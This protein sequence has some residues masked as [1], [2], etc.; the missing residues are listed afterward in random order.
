MKNYK[1]TILVISFLFLGFTQIN[2]QVKGDWLR[3]PTQL[4]G[5]E[6]VVEPVV[7]LAW[8]TPG[9]PTW[10]FYGN[11]SASTFLTFNIG[12]YELATKYESNDLF[13]YHGMSIKKFDFY[14]SVDAHPY[15]FKIWSGDDGDK[16]EYEQLLDTVNT[17]AWTTVNLTTPFVIDS[18]KTY[19]VG[20]SFDIASDGSYGVVLDNGPAVVSGKGNMIRNSEGFFV[21]LTDYGVNRNLSFFTYLELDESVKKQNIITLNQETKECNIGE[22]SLKELS[23]KIKFET[24]IS[25]AKSPSSFNIYRNNVVVGTSIESS[26]VDELPDGGEYVYEISAV[27]PEGES[28][29]SESLDVVYD[30]KRIPYNTVITETFINVGEANG[31]L[32]SGSS[33]GAFMGIKELEFEVDNI[34]PIVYHSGTAILGPDPFS[35]IDG[36]ERF[37]YYMAAT[38][39]FPMTLFNARLFQGG[40]S[41]ETMYEV[42]KD[43]YESALDLVTPIAFESSLEKI[44]S[45]KYRLNATA[46]IVGVYNDPNTVLHVVLTQETIEHSWNNEKLDDVKFVATEMF[47]DFYGTQLNFGSD[48]VAS[49]SVEVD[50]DPFLPV[51]NYRVIA[52]VQ[53]VDGY[54]I[55]NGDILTI[56]KRNNIEFTV[57]D[58]DEAPIEGAAISTNGETKTS[59]IDGNVTFAIYDNMGEVEY[60]VS[61][62]GFNVETGYF[63]MDTTENVNVKLIT[64]GLNSKVIIENKVYPNP[65]ANN[66]NI[67]AN[68][69]A[70]V[71]IMN[72][73]GVV[74]YEY[75][76]QQYSQSIDLSDLTNGI[77]L[78]NI[79]S[80]NTNK[81]FRLVKTN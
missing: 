41:S 55:W 15:T 14:G 5:P 56:P 39:S 65:T 58:G 48:S 21:S 68:I 3:P 52:F 23:D 42:Y 80:D 81:V 43:L 50:I 25:D 79:I 12:Y 6:L 8:W 57:V 54:A 63:N 1:A 13:A 31:I 59:D 62:D 34:A 32:N 18:A 17:D 33:P 64:T 76:Q 66:V 47:P 77:Y 78:I 53:S 9:A 40:G 4:N 27:Y 22:L 72:S 69:N 60:S 35:T 38:F 26:F 10:L 49:L 67:V 70:D 11:G 45:S 44:S 73:V 61:K 36:E 7:E 71:Q 29:K 75:K 19:F 28:A 74:V 16:I 20:L 30:N 37:I 46:K 24:T 2:A 51:S